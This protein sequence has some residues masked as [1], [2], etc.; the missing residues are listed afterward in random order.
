[1]PPIKSSPFP[2]P[3]PSPFYS[4]PPYI[5]TQGIGIQQHSYPSHSKH[6][7]LPAAPPSGFTIEE[8]VE[9]AAE[10]GP[11]LFTRLEEEEVHILILRKLSD[12]VL[13]KGERGRR[14]GECTD[15]LVEVVC[16]VRL[17]G[18]SL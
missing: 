9:E 5:T 14:G 11:F 6:F 10:P 16:G 13:Q 17:G 2:I 3:F 4:I 18:V 12:E 15:C 7:V 8:I 1:M